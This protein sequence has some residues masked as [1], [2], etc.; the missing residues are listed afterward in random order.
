MRSTPINSSVD[1]GAAAVVPQPYIDC[2]VY[3]NKSAGDIIK[4]MF[5]DA[6]LTD[7]SGPPSSTTRE[8]TV[9]F[10]ES[11]L[12]FATRLMEEEGWFYFFQHDEKKH[13]LVIAN[14]NVAFKDIDDATLFL[15][16]GDDDTY[17]LLD[18]N[19]A[20]ATARGKMTYRDYDPTK[21]DTLLHDE[22]P[23]TLQTSGKQTSTIR[24]TG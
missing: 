15:V 10:N 19:H 21:P 23:T 1:P 24:R 2:R 11:D 9:Q 4:A 17:K 13:T 18:F 16:G 3:Q 20:A 22:Q 6:G 7:L 8:Y 5:Q 14:Q 12:T